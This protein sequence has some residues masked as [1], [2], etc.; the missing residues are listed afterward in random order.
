MFCNP[1]LRIFLICSWV[2]LG[3]TGTSKAQVTLLQENF[4]YS[5]GDSIRNFGWYAHSAGT[6]NPI[7]VSSSGLV[8]PGSLYRCNG[9]GLAASV[10]NTGSDE[11][12]PFSNSVDTGAVYLSFMFRVNGAVDSLTSGYFLH[13]IEYANVSIPNY[14]AISTAHRGRTYLVRGSDASNYRLGLTFNSST[15]PSTPG[16]DLTPLLDTG[17]T[18][19]AVLKYHFVSGSD[20]DSVSLTV[21]DSNDSLDQ[22]PSVPTLG[23]FAGSARDLTAVQGLALRQYNAQQNITVDG[24]Y[25]SNVWALKSPTASVLDIKPNRSTIRVYPNP[26]VGGSTRVVLETDLDKGRIQIKDLQGRIVQQQQPF[27]GSIL[28][29]DLDPGF[30]WLQVQDQNGLTQGIRLWVP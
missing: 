3:L 19:L 7:L 14:N 26:A 18:Y 9:I 22:E 15:V 29:Q 6:T 1:C 13:F 27:Q 17:T 28:V 8:W 25:A 24:I 16:V 4:D 23:P 21:F 5:A 20:N 11:N 10:S 30:Y 12:K 2:F